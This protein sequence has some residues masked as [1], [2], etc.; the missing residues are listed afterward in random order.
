MPAE[1]YVIE[2]PEGSHDALMRYIKSPVTVTAISAVVAQ[3]I[4]RTTNRAIDAVTGRDMDEDKMYMGIGKA[5]S[6]YNDALETKGIPI[7][8]VSPQA[9]MQPQYAGDD[10]ASRRKNTPTPGAGKRFSIEPTR[11]RRPVRQLRPATP[12]QSE[13]AEKIQS[14]R[15]ILEE[16]KS[17]TTCGHCKKHIDAAIKAVDNETKSIVAA[18]EKQQAM[19]ELKKR[20]E[21]P[22]DARWDDLT[23]VQ[24]KKVVSTTNKKSG[25]AIHG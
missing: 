14:A 11:T 4:G 10:T 19:L 22:Q 16:V 18:A 2:I 5:I 8:A 3:A 9:F 15:G 17:T 21:L 23:P 6:A 20:G 12:T 13:I 24:K 1:D 25:V 7:D